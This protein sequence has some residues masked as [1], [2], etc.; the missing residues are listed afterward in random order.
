M[1]KGSVFLISHSDFSSLVYRNARDFWALILFPATLP[2]SLITS[3][4]FLVAY[5]AFSIY[6]IMSSANSDSFIS[7]FL[8]WIP[9][10]YLSSLIAVAKNSKTMLNK[11]GESGQP[12]LVPDLSGNGFSFSPLRM[13]LAV[14]SSYMTFIMLWKVPSMPTFWRVFIINGCWILLKLSLHLLRWSY[15]FSPS[16]C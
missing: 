2:H 7:S 3:T 6:R 14:G 15:G 1:V 13:M 10:I 16:I 12:C 8:I 11:S 4:C 9:F 5:L